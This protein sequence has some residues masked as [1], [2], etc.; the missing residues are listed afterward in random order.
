MRVVTSQLPLLVQSL[1]IAVV[2]KTEAANAQAIRALAP[3]SDSDAPVDAPQN[4]VPAIHVG[5]RLRVAG[6]YYGLNGGP[7][8]SAVDSTYGELRASGEIHEY[9]TFALS[10]YA[11]DAGQLGAQAILF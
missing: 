5:A 10:L 9:V 2:G 6:R 1:A 11:A 4:S 7:N 3:T 8:A